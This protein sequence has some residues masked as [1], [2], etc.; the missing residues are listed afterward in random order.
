[1]TTTTTKSV[2]RSVQQEPELAS[3]EC[4]PT[5]YVCLSESKCVP[6]TEPPQME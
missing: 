4:A 2:V 5:V 6:W 1:M 3:E